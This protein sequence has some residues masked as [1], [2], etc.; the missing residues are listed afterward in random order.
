MLTLV[1]TQKFILKDYFIF[2]GDMLTLQKRFLHLFERDF[3]EV[4]VVLAKWKMRRVTSIAVAI[5]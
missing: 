3:K 5:S 4:G 2:I 1:S